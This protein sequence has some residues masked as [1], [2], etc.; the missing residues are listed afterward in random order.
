MDEVMAKHLPSGTVLFPAYGKLPDDT[1]YITV[2]FANPT[3][4]TSPGATRLAG[5]RS[6]SPLHSS[7]SAEW[8]IPVD[9]PL[10]LRGFRH[11]LGLSQ[12]KF[13]VRLGQNR[14]N[15]ERWESGASRPVPRS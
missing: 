1:C 5:S 7:F 3:T 2:D 15:I 4:L 11:A 10:A 12:A 9:V 13:A 14:L 8:P 6:R